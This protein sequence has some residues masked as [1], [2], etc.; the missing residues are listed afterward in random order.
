VG[1]PLDQAE[2]LAAR[3]PYDYPAHMPS[4]DDF[5]RYVDEHGIPE[6]D[7]PAAFALWIAE[8]TGGPV[9][10]F[11]KVEREQPADRVVIEGDDL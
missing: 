7:Y 3:S 8:V 9:P 11:Q 2:A 5:D 1:R 4:L 6:E 10:R